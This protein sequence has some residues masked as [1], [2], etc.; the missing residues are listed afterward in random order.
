MRPVACVLKYV[1]VP[2][3]AKLSEL[4]P[5]VPK[6]PRAFR[7]E[8]IRLTQLHVLVQIHLL[9]LRDFPFRYAR[10]GQHPYSIFQQVFLFSVSLVSV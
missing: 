1:H 3:S 5:F 4:C 8:V 2:F 9:G 10:H 7:L 6:L